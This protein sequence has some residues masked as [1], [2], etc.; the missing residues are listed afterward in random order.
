MN[1]LLNY[2]A[3][4]LAGASLLG[5]AATANADSFSFSIHSDGFN[6]G[7]S[8][9]H[10]FGHHGHRQHYRRHIYR[11]GHYFYEPLYPYRGHLA[12]RHS[13]RPHH[14]GWHRPKHHRGH[15][16]KYRHWNK[17]RGHYRRH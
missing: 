4:L 9:G 12:H 3:Q 17:H 2:G 6:F 8:D 5:I 14:Y 11:P 13:H 1:K 7:Y 15:G 16:H 10:R